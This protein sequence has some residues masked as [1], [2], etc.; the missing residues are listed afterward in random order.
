MLRRL[1]SD[2][3]STLLPKKELYLFV[4]MSQLQKTWY[5]NLITNNLD[6]INSNGREKVRLLNMLMQL[7]K[8]CNHPYLFDNVEPM[9]ITDGEHLVQASMKF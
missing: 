1:K 9:P 7:R 8:V 4:G 6:V 2:V 3:E 5:K